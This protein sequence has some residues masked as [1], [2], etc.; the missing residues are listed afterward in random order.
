MGL[1]VSHRT[2]SNWALRGCLRTPWE[3]QGTT[4]NLWVRERVP[5]LKPSSG[6]DLRHSR[7]PPLGLR[8]VSSLRGLVHKPPPTR[9]SRAGLWIV[10]SPTGLQGLKAFK[11]AADLGHSRKPPHCPVFITLGEPQAHGDKAKNSLRKNVEQR[12]KT[13]PSAAKAEHH[14]NP[15]RTA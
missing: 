12:A 10:S 2:R 11:R 8:I 14:Y 15:L 5:H 4:A 1:A 9:H 3:P 13:V 7:K 6:S